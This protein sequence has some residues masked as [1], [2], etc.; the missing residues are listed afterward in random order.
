MYLQAH[1]KTSNEQRRWRCHR[2]VLV[3]DLFCLANLAL[4]S[5]GF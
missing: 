5:N 4:E 2:S 3:E 1:K